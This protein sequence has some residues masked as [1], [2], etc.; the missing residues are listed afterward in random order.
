SFAP[1]RFLIE[2]GLCKGELTID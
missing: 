2:A 1:S